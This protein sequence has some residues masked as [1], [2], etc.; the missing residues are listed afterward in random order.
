MEK[1][2]PGGNRIYGAPAGQVRAGAEVGCLHGTGKCGKFGKFLA[3]TPVQIFIHTCFF[4]FF[5]KAGA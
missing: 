1:S 4:P 2:R 3:L 5:E